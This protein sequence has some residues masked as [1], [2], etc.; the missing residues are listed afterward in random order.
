MMDLMLV[1]IDAV[2]LGLEVFQES[3]GFFDDGWDVFDAV[4]GNQKSGEIL[5]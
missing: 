5:R 2:I 4:D 1:T 3:D